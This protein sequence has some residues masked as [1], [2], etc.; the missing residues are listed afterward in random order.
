MIYFTLYSRSYCHLCEDMHQALSVLLKDVPHQVNVIDVD[1]DA[2][3]L[4]L[5][6]ELVPVLFA[7]RSVADGANGAGQRLCHYFLDVEKVKA[8]CNE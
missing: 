7:Q 6:D 4:N 1:E 3:L 8:F 5:Y 2:E